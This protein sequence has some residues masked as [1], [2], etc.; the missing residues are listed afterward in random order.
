MRFSASDLFGSLTGSAGRSRR[1]SVC[2]GR[3]FQCVHSSGRCGRRPG[4]AERSDRPRGSSGRRKKRIRLRYS[5]G[6]GV[7]VPVLYSEGEGGLRNLNF[8]CSP[9][10]VAANYADDDEAA[11][12]AAGKTVALKN[13]AK[14]RFPVLSSSRRSIRQQVFAGGR[15]RG[16]LTGASV[17]H[18]V[19]AC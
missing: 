1:G 19:R 3:P 12:R 6:K 15:R 9:L 13:R 16:M 7:G 10:P 17:L 14:K 4:R 11:G 18:G 2:P 8:S 5:A